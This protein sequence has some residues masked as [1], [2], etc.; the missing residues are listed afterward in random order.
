MCY[1][2]F[3]P[4]SG[5]IVCSHW[6]HGRLTQVSRAPKAGVQPSSE[7]HFRQHKTIAALKV[8]AISAVLGPPMGDQTGGEHNKAP[9]TIL[10]NWRHGRVNL[11]TD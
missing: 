2:H 1:L 4:S 10:S 5:V 9:A 11:S 3:T 7:Q 6:Q 8:Q